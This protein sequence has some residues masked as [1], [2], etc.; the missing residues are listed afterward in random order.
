MNKDLESL[1]IQ[2]CSQQ[3]D[4]AFMIECSSVFL[5]QNSAFKL[6]QDLADA[7]LSA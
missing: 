2:A 4:Q 6:A 7:A 3:T 5:T 1:Y